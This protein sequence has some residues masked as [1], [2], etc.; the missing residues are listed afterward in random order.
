MPETGRRPGAGSR[1]EAPLVGNRRRLHRDHRNARSDVAVAFLRRVLTH[2]SAEHRRLTVVG[3]AD[4]EQVGHPVCLGQEQKLLELGPDAI[5]KGIA[6]PT[7]AADFG[8]PLLARHGSSIS[9]GVISSARY[10]GTADSVATVEVMTSVSGADCGRR[11]RARRVR[12]V[13]LTA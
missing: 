6:D 9:N 12:L 13:S 8:S 3:F 7:S 5:G 2:K 10:V 11:S 1:I 4:D